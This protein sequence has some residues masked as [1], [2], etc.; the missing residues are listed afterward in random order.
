MPTFNGAV[1]RRFSWLK[2]DIQ[3]QLAIALFDTLEIPVFARKQGVTNKYQRRTQLQYLTLAAAGLLSFYKS[4]NQ[5]VRVAGLSCLFPGAGFLGVGGIFGA[6]GLVLS[7]AVLP[8]SL[9]AWFGAGGLAFVLA[10]WLIPAVV[11]SAIAK[12]V[13]EPAAPIALVLAAAGC[14]YMIVAGQKRHAAAL[15]SRASRNE[16][17]GTESAALHERTS[18]TQNQYS[19]KRELSEKELRLLQ[20]FV[21]IAHQSFDDWSN[22]NRVDQF[23]TSALRYQLYDMQYSFAAVQKHYMPNFH[24]YIKTGHENMIEK[25]A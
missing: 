9:F 21:Q 17:L 6:I 7:L 25:R 12:S 11:A 15:K 18:Q 16:F 2:A 20:H 1:S 14:I 22:F 10:N 19:G 4:D 5:H 23:Q 24:G 3:P 8:V 13:W